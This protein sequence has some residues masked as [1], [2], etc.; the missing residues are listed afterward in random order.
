MLRKH[1]QSV[2][3]QLSARVVVKVDFIRDLEVFSL[4]YAFDDDLKYT[5]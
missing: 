5:E 1:P 3:S 4:P 2:T